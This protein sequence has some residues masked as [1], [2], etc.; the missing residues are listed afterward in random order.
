MTT[1]TTK[2]CS[3]APSPHTSVERWKGPKQKDVG[4]D[5]HVPL[6][7]RV[8]SQKLTSLATLLRWLDDSGW[9]AGTTTLR[10]ATLVLVHSTAE[11]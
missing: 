3:F 7:P 2:P 10:T 8:T 4:K 6:T 9:G 5:S 1:T 11:Y